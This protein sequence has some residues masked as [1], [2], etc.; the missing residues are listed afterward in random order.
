MAQSRA[1]SDSHQTLVRLSVSAIDAKGDPV[2][3]LRTADIQVREDGS[4]R[5][6]VFLRFAG[7]KRA[8][9]APGA[10]EF[11]NRRTPPS[12]IVLLDRWNERATTLATA[13]QD[14]TAALSHLESVDR[15]YLYFLSAHGDLFPVRALPGADADLRPVETPDAAALI[16]KLNDA[17]R[18]LSGIRDVDT[19][20]AVLRANTTFQALGTLKRADLSAGRKN[21][22][23]VTHGIPMRATLPDGKWADFAVPVQ[24]LGQSAAQSQLVMYTVAQSVEGAGADPTDMDKQTLK[25]LSAL[26]GGRSY[27]TGMTGTAIADAMADA[28]GSYRLAYYSP[29]REGDKKEHKIRVDSARKGIRLL[30]AE[31]YVASEPDGDLD[32]LA[33]VTFGTLSHC[34][35]DAAEITLRAVLSRAEAPGTVHIEVHVD[36]A[37]VLLER[38]GGELQGSLT[39]RCAIY[40]NGVMMGVLPRVQKDLAFT[41]EQLNGLRDGIV[42]SQDVQVSRPNQQ[43]RV[44]VFDRALHSLGSVT[45]PTK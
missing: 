29:V 45:V 4:P 5:E 35:F 40:S 23:W 3:D 10:D 22:I 41:E 27:A 7:G 8:M 17:V 30:T 34:P 31:S 13:W 12:T 16:A 26:T 43:V 14:V 24:T 39:M 21:L 28:R 19:R 36:P 18:T 20:D 25:T 15:L 37:D 32:R 38:R 33:D 11:F 1:K 9:A 44:M 42:M 2:A 6:V